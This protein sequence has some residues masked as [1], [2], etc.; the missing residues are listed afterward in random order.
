V[1]TN[2]KADGEEAR[3]RKSKDKEKDKEGR[4]AAPRT[5]YGG[6]VV[7]TEIKGGSDPGANLRS[8]S[9]DRESTR[10]SVYTQG[11]QN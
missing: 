9:A 3:V 2:R 6:E 4:L 11:Q 1:L 10:T 5:K 7:C 8:P